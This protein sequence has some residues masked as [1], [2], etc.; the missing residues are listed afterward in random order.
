MDY[1]KELEEL[2]L[3]VILKMCSEHL[4]EKWERQKVSK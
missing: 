1:K 3:N 2:I 4:K